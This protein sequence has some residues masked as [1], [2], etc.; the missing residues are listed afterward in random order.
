MKRDVVIGIV[1][2]AILVAAMVGV[3]RYEAGRAGTAFD[4]A[5]TTSGIAG[6]T[7]DGE[8]AEGAQSELTLNVTQANLTRLVFHLN[9]TDDAGTP[10]EFEFT[11]IDPSGESQ[12]VTGDSGSLEVV[13]DNLSALPP[14]T[15]T[16]GKDEAEARARLAQQNSATAGTG[17][18]SFVVRLVDAGD[19]SV[20]VAGVPVTEDTQNSW[21]IET[22]QVAYE[23]VLTRP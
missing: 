16:L 4:V 23:P 8:T 5:W 22:L 15:R 13:F 3:F 7:A 1:G 2:A 18:W 14:P 19:Q 10:D 21:T 6:P 17:T 12:T 20:P 9:W 11:V